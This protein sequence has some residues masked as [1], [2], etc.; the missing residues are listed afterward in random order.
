MEKNHHEALRPPEN[1]PQN[2]PKEDIEVAINQIIAG[3]G[4][5]TEKK[6]IWTN[7]LKNLK[8]WASLLLL[9]LVC[10][11]NYLL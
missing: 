1:Y 9:D 5:I 10:L 6:Q 2:E 3:L 8:T 4:K 11:K 7:P